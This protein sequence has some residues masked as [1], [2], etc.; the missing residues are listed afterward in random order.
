MSFMKKLFLRKRERPRET[1]VRF[2][3]GPGGCTQDRLV[4]NVDHDA[5]EV[6]SSSEQQSGKMSDALLA[7]PAASADNDSASPDPAVTADVVS[8]CVEAET[9]AA[10][11][12]DVSDAIVAEDVPADNEVDAELESTIKHPPHGEVPSAAPAQ[13]PSVKITSSEPGE[14]SA[15]D[16]GQYDIFLI[17]SD[18]DQENASKFADILVRF[19]KSHCGYDLTVHPELDF[20]GNKL[21][22]LRSGLAR[23]RCRFIFIDDGFREDDLV[24]FGTDAALMEMIDRG[25]QSIIPV[26]AHAGIPTPPLLKMFK[27]LDVHKLLNGRRLDT[28]LDA[29]VL[30][31]TDIRVPVLKNIVRMVS[32]SEFGSSSKLSSA[33]EQSPR[34]ASQH[35]EIIRKHFVELGDAIDPDSGLVGHLFSAGV[36]NHREMENVQAEKTL[37]KR[38]EYLLKLL[39]RKSESDYLKFVD[40]LRK[41]DQSYVVDIL[42]P[43]SVDR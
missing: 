40:V 43:G 20:G 12:R 23:S 18:E 10:S 15:S 13:A 8:D 1:G 25:D 21:E 14:A 35:S 19:C 33:G 29:G 37:Y 11:N 41:V 16:L 3:T 38:N 4:I 31:E 7:V 9:A 24:R 36:V 17:T 28:V 42:C 22:H 5:V 34:T 32:R 30:A 26:R 27:S 39:M 6:T 2:K